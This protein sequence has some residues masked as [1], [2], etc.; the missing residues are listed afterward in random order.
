MFNNKISKKNR[1]RELI[2]NRNIVVQPFIILYQLC[3]GS[4]YIGQLSDMSKQCMI[5]TNKKCIEEI[6]NILLRFIVY[7]L[8]CFGL[9]VVYDFIIIFN[10][11]IFNEDNVSDDSLKYAQHY[12]I[13]KIKKHK[14][15]TREKLKK[16]YNKIKTSRTNIKSQA[17]ILKYQLV[18]TIKYQLKNLFG[19]KNTHNELKKACS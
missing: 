4:M 6:F 5:L 10:S 2:R 16:M 19:R 1:D 18:D 14:S 13:D 9:V 17:N 15:G 7:E 3:L 11:I 12:K 8:F